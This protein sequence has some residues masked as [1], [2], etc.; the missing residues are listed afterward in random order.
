ML[1]VIPLYSATSHQQTLPFTAS[2]SRMESLLR[3]VVVMV[4][5]TAVVTVELVPTKVLPA[6]QQTQAPAEVVRAQ[7]AQTLYKATDYS[8][9]FPQLLFLLSPPCLHSLSHVYILN[10]VFSLDCMG[11]TLLFLTLVFL[12]IMLKKFQVP[13]FRPL[14]CAFYIIIII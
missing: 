4:L 1:L 5:V 2:G 6:V 8:V 10:I 7:Y 13:S 14:V 9:C 3:V 11:K 12:R